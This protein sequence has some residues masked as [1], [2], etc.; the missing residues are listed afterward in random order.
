V[1]VRFYTLTGV[2]PRDTP[3]NATLPGPCAREALKLCALSRKYQRGHAGKQVSV[4]EAA[5]CHA[6]SAEAAFTPSEASPEA[7]LLAST[8]VKL[9][10]AGAMPVLNDRHMQ[11][12]LEALMTTI[13]R[14]GEEASGAKPR[15]RRLPKS[16]NCPCGAAFF[17]AISELHAESG[18]ALFGNLAAQMD[19]GFIRGRRY[20][21][22]GRAELQADVLLQSRDILTACRLGP[23]SF[24]KS[25]PVGPA[26]NQRG[27]GNRW[28]RLHGGWR[29]GCRLQCWGA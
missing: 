17:A 5:D 7:R 16:W 3:H 20:A 24:L 10:L 28:R 1:F 19:D 22:W 29:Q 6:Q 23:T 9:S 25:R 27:P 15:I 13:T 21:R 11:D 18:S 8:W 26:A 4:P 12:R 14:R 2:S